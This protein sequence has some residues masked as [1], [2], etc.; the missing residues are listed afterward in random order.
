MMF[1]LVARHVDVS[2]KVN[3]GGMLY[4][5]PPLFSHGCLPVAVFDAYTLSFIIFY[6]SIQLDVIDDAIVT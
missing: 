2:L 4:N 1:Q 6:L 3:S 5:I